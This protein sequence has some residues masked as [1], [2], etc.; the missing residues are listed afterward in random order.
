MACGAQSSDTTEKYCGGF[1]NT[2]PAATSNI[3]VCREYII[4]I[5]LCNNLR[6]VTDLRANKPDQRCKKFF[7]VAFEQSYLNL[8]FLHCLFFNVMTSS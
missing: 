7:I 2:F 5:Y 1:F 8:I 6:N 3:A 4:Y